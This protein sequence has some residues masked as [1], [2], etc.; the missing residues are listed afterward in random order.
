MDSISLVKLAFLAQQDGGAYGAG[1]IAG[2]IFIVV[3]AGAI[4]WKFLKKK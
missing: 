3:L 2:G 4:L 1:Q